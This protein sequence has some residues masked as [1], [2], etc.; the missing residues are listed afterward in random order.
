[1]KTKQ[2][3][4]AQSGRSMIEMLGVLAVIGILSIGGIWMYDYASNTY[5]SNQIQKTIL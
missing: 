4:Q 5:Q 2:L 3:S 1:M